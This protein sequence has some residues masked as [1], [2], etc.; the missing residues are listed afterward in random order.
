[1][2]ARLQT[3]LARTGGRESRRDAGPCRDNDRGILIIAG[4]PGM[5][6]APRE[7]TEAE[8]EG[9]AVTQQ[10]NNRLVASQGGAAAFSLCEEYVYFWPDDRRKMFLFI[11]LFIYLFIF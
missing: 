1:M 7:A 11:Y 8:S 9:G 5:T 3:R 4:S 2:N 10:T 6:P